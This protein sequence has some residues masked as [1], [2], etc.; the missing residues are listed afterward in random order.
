MVIADYSSDK[1]DISEELQQHGVSGHTGG[2]K[3]DLHFPD[4]QYRFSTFLYT[5]DLSY[6]LNN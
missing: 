5:V 2:G 1:T 4:R 3:E 6:F